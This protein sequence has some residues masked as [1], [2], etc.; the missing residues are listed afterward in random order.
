MGYIVFI[1]S[2]YMRQ[3]SNSTGRLQPQF[4]DNPLGAADPFDGKPTEDSTAQDNGSKTSTVRWKEGTTAVARN[5]VLYSISTAN[6]LAPLP[7]ALHIGSN[8]TLREC[9]GQGRGRVEGTDHAAWGVGSNGNMIVAFPSDH[10]Q[11]Q[12]HLAKRVRN[13]T[14]EIQQRPARMSGPCFASVYIWLKAWWYMRTP[15]RGAGPFAASYSAM[16]HSVPPTARQTSKKSVHGT[17]S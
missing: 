8:R 13:G 1:A 9:V 14:T 7:P 15:S 5:N 3:P 17:S 10:T 4:A 16:N 6:M 2:T 12:H 11:R